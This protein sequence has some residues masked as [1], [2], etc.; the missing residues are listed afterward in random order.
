[1]DGFVTGTAGANDDVNADVQLAISDNIQAP[2]DTEA[3]SGKSL[4]LFVLLPLDLRLPH[5]FLCFL[6]SANTC[7]EDASKA[8][9]STIFGLQKVVEIGLFIDEQTEDWKWA[10][11]VIPIVVAGGFGCFLVF[12]VV[13]E[14]FGRH[15]WLYRDFLHRL[16]YSRGLGGDF[17]SSSK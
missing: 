3:G 9:R 12:S 11:E 15:R 13:F 7:S 10:C 4:T 14:G 8:L 16:V 5:L 6:D 1:M 2:I 17:S